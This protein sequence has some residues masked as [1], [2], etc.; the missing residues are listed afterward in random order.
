MDLDLNLCSLVGHGAET[1]ISGGLAVQRGQR[2]VFEA[3]CSGLFHGGAE[4]VRAR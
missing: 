2:F 4:V 1:S 3:R